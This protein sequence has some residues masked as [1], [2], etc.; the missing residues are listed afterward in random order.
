MKTILKIF[1]IALLFSNCNKDENILNEYDLWERLIDKN[2]TWEVE[3]LTTKD[4]S[5]PN[6]TSSDLEPEFEFI[7]FYMRTYIFGSASINDHNANLYNGD[8]YSQFS[9]EAEEQRVVFH[10]YQVFGGDVWT[11]KENKRNKQIWTFTSGKN[12]AT[13]TLVRC[14]C[15]IPE[16]KGT[17]NGG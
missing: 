12:T 10:N 1:F 6:S 16:I 11:V 7:H 13:L 9:C 5:D 4:N 15:K 14:N 17:E 3:S 2:G 8:N